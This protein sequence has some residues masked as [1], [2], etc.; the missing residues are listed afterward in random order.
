MFK[1]AYAKSN[2]L[3]GLIYARRCAR[4]ALLRLKN[5]RSNSIPLAT[6]FL[7]LHYLYSHHF[8]KREHL[9][10]F[11]ISKNTLWASLLR[12]EFRFTGK[13]SLVFEFRFADKLSLVFE[14]RFERQLCR[15]ALILRETRVQSSTWG[16]KKKF[17]SAFL[18]AEVTRWRR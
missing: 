14:F 12:F 17:G 3:V 7:I 11:W 16:K 13:L 15:W 5:F 8:C 18:A 2:M 1:L 9:K 6:P 4:A 10:I